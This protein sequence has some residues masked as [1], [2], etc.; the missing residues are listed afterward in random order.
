MKEVLIKRIFPP[1][2]K[3]GEIEMKKGFSFKISIF[4]YY[5]L[6]TIF[7]ITPFTLTVLFA[8]A[9]GEVVGKIIDS[10]TKEF[11]IGA[12]VQIEGLN[13][14]AA[15]D[16]RG[17]FRISKLPFGSHTLVVKYIGYEDFSQKFNVSSNEPV[18]IVNA[19][20]KISA[21][22]ME[23]I[24]V[25][26]LLEG[27]MKALN[28][29][30][31]ADNIKS[32]VAREQMS[33][34]PDY[35]AAEVIKRLPGVTLD[36]ALGEG[37]YVLIRGTEPRLS[38]VTV[39]GLNLAS[40]RRKERY[41]QLDII[42]ANQ[43]QSMEVVK[44]LT[45]DMD[46]NAIGG[47]VNIITRSAF[48]NVGN[49]FFIS[50]GLGYNTLGG[51]P[52]YQGMMNFSGRFG[53][54][55]NIGVVIT[56]N[57]DRADRQLNNTKYV[58]DEVTDAS[59]NKIPFALLDFR[60][61]PK[62]FLRT[63]YGIG[64]GLEYKVNNDHS[65][66]IR[67]T[68]NKFDDLGLR[69]DTY[70]IRFDRGKFITQNQIEG[71]QISRSSNNRLEALDQKAFSVGGLS[72]FGL[73]NLDYKIA[74][75]SGSEM[76]PDEVNNEFTFAPKINLTLDTSIPIAPKWNV[77]NMEENL[78]YDP[79]LFKFN[80]LTYGPTSSTNKNLNYSVNVSVPYYLADFS[81]TLKF[82]ARISFNDK[83]RGID[84][85]QYKWTGSGTI[86]LKNFIFTDLLVKD[87][88]DGK[89]TYGYVTDRDKI[90]NF[91]N[92]ERDKGLQGPW[93]EERNKTD[94]FEANEKIYAGYV[95]TTNNFG[96][97]MFLG[98]VR[99]EYINI[100]YNAFALFYDKGVYKGFKPVNEGD[101]YG[102]LLPMIHFRYSLTEMTNLR[103]AFTNTL[104]R[105]NYWDLAPRFAIDDNLLTISKGNTT[106][107][108]TYATNID[109]MGEHYLGSVGVASVSLYYKKLTDII[110]ETTERLT[111]G[112]Y[113]GYQQ[114]Q[115]I[116][117]GDASLFGFEI[118][119]QQQLSFLPG[120]WNGFGIYFNYNHT[121]ADTDLSGR[122]GFLPGQAG[123]TGNLSLIYDKY[124]LSARLSLNFQGKF[125]R[126]IGKN[127]DYDNYSNSYTQ[128][129][130][131]ANQKL[132]K[133]LEVFFEWVN[134]T[135]DAQ[136]FY[137]GDISRPVDKLI[138]CWSMMFG[139]R[140][141]M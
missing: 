44:A 41:S 53:E 19:A 1:F 57:Y 127:K 104:S 135:N 75:S 113:T 61:N 78:Q 118:N 124:G 117:G 5:L 141:T 65:F 86:L 106:L 140:W 99:F 58:W 128:L 72:K 97:L 136:I 80:T 46:A 94:S 70:R 105:P 71:V 133:G 26:G 29:Q 48:D 130:F 138:I 92:Q 88:A 103:A 47:T 49:T 62:R 126:A 50:G 79:E 109:I 7:F 42:G 13:I 35:N 87:Y 24:V 38:N 129:D 123:D 112:V 108:P 30:R 15:S 134:I 36:R 115:P 9:S 137:M 110:F 20:M 67:G 32:V 39:D 25:Q 98:G 116:N 93:N 122:E 28:Q 64:F 95:M 10:N 77:T 90:Y 56:L 22:E 17:E 60:M 81:S 4:V 119:W 74:Y 66:F 52:T 84:Q 34:F 91:F 54:N 33:K 55:Q 73:F 31:T 69:S 8:Q 121:W 21:L 63:R 120:F 59:K 132:Y 83:T 102:D 100:D 16:R 131:S 82:G 101:K 40:T 3:K 125:I 107:V 27:Q 85:W 76:H 37:R 43:M 51:K 14:G 2:I 18:V 12:N 11:L 96:K 23:A 45:P 68:N 89:Y 111:T 114:T 139:L 6:F